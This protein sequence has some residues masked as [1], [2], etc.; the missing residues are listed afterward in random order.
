VTT[1]LDAL[2]LDPATKLELAEKLGLYTAT[3][4]PDTRSVE[5]LVQS[6][7]LDGAAI[8]SGPTGYRLARDSAE[9]EECCRRLRIRAAH[10]FITARAMRRTAARIKAVE[11]RP[12]VV[13][14]PVPEG[15]KVRATEWP[16]WR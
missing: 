1:L 10:Q 2:T 16:A 12:L 15:R 11:D 8:V 9:I 13:D 4:K 3:G 5:A 14:L 6:Y 7:R